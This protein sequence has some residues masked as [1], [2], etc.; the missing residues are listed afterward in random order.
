MGFFNQKQKELSKKNT[1]YSLMKGYKRTEKN[2]ERAAKS[3][4]EQA[5]HTAMAKHQR[6]EYA[7]LY[8]NTPEY[9]RS[10]KNRWKR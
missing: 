2:L 9:K 4:N 3:G 1:Y 6:Y 5:L 7:L 8:R 10:K